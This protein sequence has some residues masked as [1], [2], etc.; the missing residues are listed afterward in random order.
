MSLRFR[1]F[2]KMLSLLPFL[3]VLKLS[4]IIGNIYLPMLY[5]PEPVLSMI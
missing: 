3:E 2:V 1:F 4:S 5:T